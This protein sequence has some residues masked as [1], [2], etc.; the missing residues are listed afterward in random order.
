MR[1]LYVFIEYLNSDVRLMYNMCM[2][3]S[4]CVC[5]NKNEHITAFKDLVMDT[6]FQVC[7]AQT[8]Q[9]RQL[10]ALCYLYLSLSLS[11]GFNEDQRSQTEAFR[12]KLARQR[13]SLNDGNLAGGSSALLNSEWVRPALSVSHSGGDPLRPLSKEPE[14]SVFTL[15]RDYFVTLM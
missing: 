4:R 9:T 8:L 7:L 6:R 13:S 3:L 1:N 14:S 10:S 15:N 12:R 5:M 2:S 11:S